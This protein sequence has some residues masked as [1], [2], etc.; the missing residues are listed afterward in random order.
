METATLTIAAM[1]DIGA[2]RSTLLD[3]PGALGTPNV[4]RVG[5]YT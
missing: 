1:D 4:P 3:P 2:G 5:A